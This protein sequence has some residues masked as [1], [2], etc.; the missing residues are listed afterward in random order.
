MACRTITKLVTSLISKSWLSNLR[1]ERLTLQSSLFQRSL[2]T[3]LCTLSHLILNGGIWLIFLWLTPHS[4]GV[5]VFV[6]VLRQ[7]RR[8]GPTGSPVAFATKFGWVLNGQAEPSSPAECVTTHYT[9][10]EF[11]DD[12]L[13]KFWEIEETPTS[14]AA[15]SLEKR[16]VLSHFKTNHSR[17]EEGRFVVSLPKFPD[18]KQI[19]ESCSQAVG[20]V[21]SLLRTPVVH[22]FSVYLLH[23]T[24]PVTCFFLLQKW[25]SSNLTVLESIKPELLDSES[26]HHIS[27]K[28]ENTKTLGLEW[29]TNLDE[30]HIA[31]N[32]APPSDHVTKQILVPDIAKMYDVLGWLSPTIVKMKILLQRV[33]ELKINWDE[34]IP[35]TVRNAWLR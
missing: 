12:T 14:E 32:E 17:T 8:T 28:C 16:N 34:P 33:W 4:P 15:V 9:S 23:S 6:E 10:V 35:D 26:T 29:D 1:G 7:G 24:T 3:C 18:A 13:R 30:F 21:L 25:N 22:T 20:K 5:D 27:D 31:V 11:K 19:G 2:A